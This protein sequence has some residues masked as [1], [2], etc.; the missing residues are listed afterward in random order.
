MMTKKTEADR[1]AIMR[2]VK[3]VD[4][5]PEMAVRR[6]VHR[7]GY[8]FRLHR[9]SLPGTPDLVSPRLRKVVFVN[10]CFWHGHNCA[11]GGRTPKSNRDYWAAKIERNRE[12]DQF[13]RDLLRA[14]GWEVFIAWECRV[15]GAALKDELR[16]FLASPGDAGEP[17]D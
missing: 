13:N 3:S 1:S 11:R 15:K 2:A 4:T 9:K 10:G 14:L 8:R 6:L 17:S 5:E 16:A 12:R 7:L